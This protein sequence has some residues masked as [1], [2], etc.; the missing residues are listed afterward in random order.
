MNG[1]PAKGLARALSA[2]ALAGCAL[3]IC[4]HLIALLG[5]YYKAILN[6]QLAL[7]FGI[8]PLA[9]PVVL[10]QERLLSELSFR[11]RMFGRKLGYNVTWK[12]LLVKTPEWLRRTVTALMYY[13]I[14]SFVVF[15]FKNFSTKVA[16]GHDELWIVSAYGAFFYSAFA[17]IL[18]SYARSERPLRPDEI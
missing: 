9:I 18:M 1:L 4:I 6:F 7:M 12:I 11:D 3:S 14:A 16:S 2:V 5:F 13:T 17:A 8:F 10:A 15:L